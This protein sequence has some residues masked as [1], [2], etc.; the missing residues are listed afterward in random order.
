[1]FVGDAAGFLH[2]I[3][4]SDGTIAWSVELD[5]HE[6][7][8]I[9]SSPVMAGDVLV[10]G[11]AS[12]ELASVLR[13]YTFRGSVVGLD[14]ESGAELWRVY[15]TEDDATS[16]AGVSVWSSAAYDAGRGTI[17]IGTG[18]TYEE[19]AAPRSDALMALDAATGDIVWIRQFT[20]GDV[21]TIFMR[22]P[23]GPDADIGGAPNLFSIGEQ[24]VVGVG[25]KAGV[26]AVLDRDSGEPVWAVQLGE[27][28]HLGGVMTTAAVG[29][30]AIFLASNTWV[31]IFDFADDGNT[32]VTYA[33]AIED[34]AILWQHPNLA[35]VFGAFTLAAGVVYHGTIDGTVHARDAMS[36]DELWAVAPGGDLG[37][38]F[39]VVD[40]RLF[41]GHGF[42]FFTA[43]AEPMGGF[44]AYGLP[45]MP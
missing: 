36:G 17:Y 10:I 11:V 9:Y 14:P 8:G 12:I 24:D 41:V 44:A 21:Y 1:V 39:S 2:R 31:D 43:P 22:Q 45:T 38:G 4:R 29:D 34:G 40:G 26:Y 42:W 19:P 27:G 18:N 13:D 35:P 3:A 32:S 5:A 28:S 33:L 25:D 20:E 6:A 15:T 37:G 30:G 23:Q 16:G 7:T